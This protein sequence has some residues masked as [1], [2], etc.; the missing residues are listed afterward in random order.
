MPQPSPI[1][2]RSA[3]D[4]Y[5]EPCRI[6]SVIWEG[7]GSAGNTVEIT[8]R[9]NPRR[10]LWRGRAGVAQH[11]VTHIFNPKG[12]NDSDGFRLQQISSGLVMVYL[13]ED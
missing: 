9:E 3:G 13:V 7:S 6:A 10:I 1:I 11:Y 12:L 2:L 8:N 5:T 4:E